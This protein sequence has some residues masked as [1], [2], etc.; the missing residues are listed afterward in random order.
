MHLT[1]MVLWVAR[2]WLTAEPGVE[3]QGMRMH[4]QLIGRHTLL[5]ASAYSPLIALLVSACMPGDATLPRG[6]H[7]SPT[8]N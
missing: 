2:F 1:V 4:W 3:R 6:Q 5:H 8:H 7:R